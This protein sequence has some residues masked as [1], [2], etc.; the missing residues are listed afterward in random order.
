MIK[1]SD[2]EPLSS[3]GIGSLPHRDSV[4][5][6]DLACGMD[7][8]YF[9][10]LPQVDFH[11]GILFQALGGFPGIFWKTGGKP[12]FELAAWERGREVLAERLGR[13]FL[14]DPNQEVG[15]AASEGL[16]RMFLE[17]LQGHPG[18]WAKVQL[19]G[20]VTAALSIPGLDHLAPSLAMDLVAQVSEWLLS[21]ALSLVADLGRAGKRA[22]FFWDEPALATPEVLQ[23]M[24]R[25]AAEQLRERIEVLKNF[26]A[27]VG[28]HC[29]GHWN[30]GEQLPWPQHIVSLDW[31]LSG[32]PLLKES[33]KLREFRSR[34]GRLAL[35]LVPTRLPSTWNSR[36]EVEQCRTRFEAAFGQEEARAFLGESLLT[37]ACG[38]GLR[39]LPDCAAVFS[40][41]RECQEYLRDYVRA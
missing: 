36:Q 33:G 24:A 15:L 21:K 20:P 2:I 17:R 35:G 29:C 16:W 25:L 38:L 41:L 26:G 3:T 5:A 13:A 1:S 4:A 31:S 8:P 14:P 18:S 7:I 32:D 19:L 34:G 23:P 40:A 10:T 39:T 11:E 28:I 12:F 30:F 27:V 9:P 37:P 6:L 22:M